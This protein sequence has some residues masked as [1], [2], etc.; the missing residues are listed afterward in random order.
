MKK[1]TIHQIDA[2]S[3][4]AFKG[5]PAGVMLID[6]TVSERWMQCMAAEMNLSETA[7]LLPE[8]EGYRIHYF[9]PEVEIPLCGHAT[10]ASAH[11]LYETELISR[12][13]N[14]RFFSNAGPLTV[15]SEEEWIVMDFPAYPLEQAMVPD[16]FEQYLGFRPQECYTSSYGWLIAVA[17]SEEEI[18]QCT[19]DFEGMK[20]NNLGHVMITAPSKQ[21]DYVVRCFAPSAGIN[22]DPVT[23]SA[24][25]ALTPL[26][27][28]K[29]GRSQFESIQVST[30]SGLLKTALQNDRVLIKGLCKTIFSAE[31]KI[32]VN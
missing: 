13:E 1:Y 29:T 9:T 2:F 15:H 16:I 24:Q 20:R 14:I 4:E 28:A 11:W 6:E 10:L 7:F 19:P 32:T 5:N 25:C 17:A 23:G 26:W 21:A 3:D 22:E 18:R 8:G 31:L 30:R 27:H 12:K